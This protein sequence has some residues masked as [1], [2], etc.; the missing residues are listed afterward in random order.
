MRT[1]LQLY[2]VYDNTQ[3]AAM[4]LAVTP[5]LVFASR[6]LP[7]RGVARYGSARWEQSRFAP[8]II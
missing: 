1:P 6:T 2:L 4:G 3:A 5:T 7:Y 8:R